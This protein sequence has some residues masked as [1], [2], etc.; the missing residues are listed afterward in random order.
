M[1]WIFIN[2]MLKFVNCCNPWKYRDHSFQLLFLSSQKLLFIWKENFPLVHGEQ[3]HCHACYLCYF[4]RVFLEPRKFERMRKKRMH[5]VSAFMQ[6]RGYIV[7]LSRSIH[8]NK[9]RTGFG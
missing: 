5:G 6:H 2:P 3:F 1:I 8:E 4:H 9:W 7:H